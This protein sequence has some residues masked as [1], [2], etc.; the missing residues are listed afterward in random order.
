M[1]YR[2]EVTADGRVA[3]EGKGAMSDKD[4][5]HWVSEQEKKK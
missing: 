1:G 3:P 5:A 2:V 4:F